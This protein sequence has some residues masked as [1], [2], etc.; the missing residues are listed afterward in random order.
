[1]SLQCIL[2]LLSNCVL[3]AHRIIFQ[4]KYSIYKSYLKMHRVY[5][6]WCSSRVPPFATLCAVA[7]QAP[8]SMGFSRQEYRSGL[9]LSSPGELPDPG[10][11]PVSPAFQADSLPSEPPEKP[12]ES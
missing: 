8:L 2:S 7:H 9:P 1:M 11:E 12:M 6:L 5:V 10:I 3:S 4:L